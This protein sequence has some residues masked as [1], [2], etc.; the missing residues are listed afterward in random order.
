MTP[1]FSFTGPER[2]KSRRQPLASPLSQCLKDLGSRTLRRDLFFQGRKLTIK[3][4][5]PFP[6]HN[7]DKKQDLL[8]LFTK[9]LQ[10]SIT[11]IKECALHK[12]NIRKVTQ[13]SRKAP[14]R[15]LGRLCF[16]KSRTQSVPSWVLPFSSKWIKTVKSKGLTCLILAIFAFHISQRHFLTAGKRERSFVQINRGCRFLVF[17]LISRMAPLDERRSS[18]LSR[19]H[20]LGRLVP[21]SVKRVCQDSVRFSAS[22]RSSVKVW[23]LCSVLRC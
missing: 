2:R 20:S 18:T 19:T 12:R 13:K 14:I 15:P 4:I 5:F 23:M 11:G 22:E 7:D 3:T 10:K 8:I 17:P 6:R 21:S 1:F 9:L 16:T